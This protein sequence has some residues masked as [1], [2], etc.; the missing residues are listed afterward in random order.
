MTIL[1][2][3]RSIFGVMLFLLGILSGLS[4]S[5][6]VVSGELEARV[7]NDNPANAGLNINCPLM[8]ASGEAG[9]IRTTIANTSNEEVSPAVYVEISHA[10]GA[11]HVNETLL[12]EPAETKSIQWTVDSSDVIF[13]RLI[14]VS[15]Q[16]FQYSDLPA[17]I[18][19]CGIL[20]GDFFGL[21]GMQLFALLFILSLAAMLIGALLWFFTHKPLDEAHGNIARAGSL[22]AVTCI[23]ALLSASSRWWGIALF[24]D[25]FSFLA[26]GIIMTEFTMSPTKFR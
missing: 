22:M 16:Q 19:Y 20:L 2:R 12:L 15:V 5:G 14:L 13:N 21:T 9:I 6:A 10:G 25:G 11:R 18:G 24:L 7:Y 23:A 3:I 4:L 1:R 26:F 17:H 8:L